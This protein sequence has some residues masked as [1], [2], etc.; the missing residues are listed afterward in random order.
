VNKAKEIAAGIARLVEGAS[1]VTLNVSVTEWSGIARHRSRPPVIPKADSVCGL[2]HMG[3]AR[4]MSPKSG[5]CSLT[6]SYE[7]A[8]RRCGAL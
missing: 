1:K 6:V 7:V 3:V 8:A 2:V 5:R 4:A